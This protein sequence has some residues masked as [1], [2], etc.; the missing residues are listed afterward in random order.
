[1]LGNRWIQLV[2]PVG[3]GHLESA[4]GIFSMNISQF[5]EERHQKFSLDFQRC[6]WPKIGL[7][8][9]SLFLLWILEGTAALLRKWYLCSPSFSSCGRV[10]E[11]RRKA[12][13]GMLAVNKKGCA[14][15][16]GCSAHCRGPGHL[17]HPGPLQDI[18]PL[19]ASCSPF[20]KCMF[21]SG[22]HT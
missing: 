10:V 15:L 3:F 16:W 9:W 21:G 18:S 14:V 20:V 7:K 5:P 19:S 6:L 13:I 22:K 11:A 17:S 1:M 8:L 4:H 2:P 12:R